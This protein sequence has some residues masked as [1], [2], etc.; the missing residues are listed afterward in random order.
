MALAKVPVGSIEDKSAYQFYVGGQWVSTSPTTD[1][2]AAYIP[3]AGG[4][5]GQGT[6]YYSAPWNQY[7]WI[8][9]PGGCACTEFIVST[10]PAPEGPWSA[11]SHVIDV[12][13]GNYPGIGA[14][15]MQAHPEYN[16]GPNENAIYVTYTQQDQDTPYETPLYLIEWN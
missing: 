2:T 6:F 10:A 5:P 13:P 4:Q 11:S 8:G 1:N 7:V 16:P 3:L 9:Q 12:P 15:T 14:Y